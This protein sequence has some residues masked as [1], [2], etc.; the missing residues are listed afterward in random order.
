MLEAS[1]F[2]NKNSLQTHFSIF[3]FMKKVFIVKERNDNHIESQ[4][5]CNQILSM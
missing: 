1:I 5:L 2:D 4:L 3:R